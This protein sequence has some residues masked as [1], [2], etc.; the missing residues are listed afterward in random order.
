[1]TRSRRAPTWLL[2]CCAPLLLR[3][4]GRCWLRS[5]FVIG[6]PRCTRDSPTRPAVAREASKEVWDTAWDSL[7]PA[8]PDGSPISNQE[9]LRLVKDKVDETYFD[10]DGLRELPRV[11]GLPRGKGFFEQ[12]NDTFWLKGPVVVA[13]LG[14]LRTISVSDP[15]M[16]KQI[17]SER[18]LYGKGFL[19]AV[20]QDIFGKALITASDRELW[21]SRRSATS[22]GFHAQW[23]RSLTEDFA[24]CTVQAMRVLDDRVKY[25]EVVDMESFFLNL[26]LDT[27]G[28]TIFGYDFR[29]S[30]QPPNSPQSPIV[31]AVYR[32]LKERTEYR[33]A[34]L[35]NL[36]LMGAPDALV[37]L[38]APSVAE[39]RQSLRSIDA[40]LDK[41]INAALQEQR[42][43]DEAELRRRSGGTLLQFII[44][45][46]GKQASREQLQDDLRTL[47]I[48]GH[49]TVA[50]TLT[51]AI[52]E[53]AK[54]PKAMAKAKQ[55]VQKVMGS[56]D[57]PTYQDVKDMKY[58]R[59]VLTEALRLFPA[60]PVLAR[61]PLKSVTLPMPAGGNVTLSRGSLLLLQLTQLHRHPGIY[62]RPDEFWP[63]RWEQ[64]FNSTG[65]YPVQGWR[66]YDPARVTGLYPT[67][68]ATDYAFIGFGGGEFQCVGDQF[69]M[70]EGTAVM[71]MLL[72]RYNFKLVDSDLEAIGL[73]MAATIHTKR[74]LMMRVSRATG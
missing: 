66:G 54:S 64:G 28:R 51:W 22:A 70:I 35:A 6:G 61:S 25:G 13:P 41:V 74:G 40:V 21:Q 63:E 59:L 7:L 18:E 65:A 1:M 27:V 47:L 20:G 69:A 43:T 60:P 2:L 50:S 53:L 10:E 8:G 56:R 52:Y 26:A 12:M 44:D 9:L 67:A 36:L 15:G 58:I 72:Q 4:L 57:S 46:S 62:E 16:I 17:L 42:L 49:E 39:Y 34:N 45:L 30:E 3:W 33:Q 5:S 73:D 32:V 24:L 14:P 38:A 31:R 23:L 55:E 71:A 29:A 68:V 11:D 37:D 48:A 19:A